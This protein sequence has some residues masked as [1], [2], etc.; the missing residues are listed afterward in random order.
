M[1]I[2]CAVGFVFQLLCDYIDYWHK[3]YIKNKKDEKPQHKGVDFVSSILTWALI[4]VSSNSKLV[5]AV[6][7]FLP[8]AIKHVGRACTGKLVLSD[9]VIDLTAGLVAWVISCCLGRT[10]K[11]KLANIKQKFRGDKNASEK[12][13]KSTMNFSKKLN[14]CGMKINLS[15]AIVPSLISLIYNALFS[16]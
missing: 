6:L 13:A 11:N 4:C 16:N 12:I 5:N 15:F 9:L 14:V 2:G 3:R 7:I 10:K 8:I 1:L